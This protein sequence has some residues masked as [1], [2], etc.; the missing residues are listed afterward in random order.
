MEGRS[1]KRRA[2]QKEK[3]R[4]FRM[5]RTYLN[6]CHS[7]GAKRP[8]NPVKIICQMKFALNLF[9][10]LNHYPLKST[11]VES[12]TVAMFNSSQNTRQKTLTGGVIVFF[13]QIVAGT[14]TQQR[15]HINRVHLQYSCLSRSFILCK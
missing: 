12:E 13:A 15:W 4:S 10:F 9:H 6:R 14:Q 2:G 7:E 5:I 11:C 1:R 8:K 3:P